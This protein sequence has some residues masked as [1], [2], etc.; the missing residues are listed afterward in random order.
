MFSACPHVS[1]P[2]ELYH[3]TTYTQSCLQPQKT[4]IIRVSLVVSLF[5]S[6]LAFICHFSIIQ[7]VHRLHCSPFDMN[8]T[9]H[10][11]KLH[12][13][14]NAI[15]FVCFGFWVYV[16]RFHNQRTER[17]NGNLHLKCFSTALFSPIANSLQSKNW[18]C[19]TW[20]IRWK[21]KPNRN[22]NPHHKYALICK[23][24]LGFRK[25]PVNVSSSHFKLSTGLFDILLNK[26]TFQT[27]TH[28][29]WQIWIYKCFSRPTRTQFNLKWLLQIFHKIWIA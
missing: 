23:H 6:S 17:N 28:H 7:W 14:L 10:R 26:I 12:R 8:Y 13:T 1:K 22:F 27:L 15:D 19:Q 20:L 9:L 24:V 11:N 5:F 16:F 3:H 2:L 21:W 25:L 18:K 4:F 29:W